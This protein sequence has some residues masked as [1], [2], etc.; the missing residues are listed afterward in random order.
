ML[1]AT[2]HFNYKFS[3]IFSY[4]LSH[5]NIHEEGS[6]RLLLLLLNLLLLLLLIFSKVMRNKVFGELTWAFLS[7]AAGLF[8]S[9]DGIVLNFP[10][11]YQ[12][13]YATLFHVTYIGQT[14]FSYYSVLGERERNR[15]SQPRIIY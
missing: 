1:Y 15:C 4:L 12:H 11:L 13:A 3:F 10:H 9:V 2:H 6:Q 14:S 7:S 8:F 5:S